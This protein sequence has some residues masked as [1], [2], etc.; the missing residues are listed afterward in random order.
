MFASK[1]KRLLWHIPHG[2]LAAYLL[3]KTPFIWA[4]IGWVA[5]IITYQFLEEIAI[6]DKSYLDFRGYMVGFA[7][8]ILLDI[9]VGLRMHV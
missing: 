3:T 1:W 4:G 2:V 7:A 9:V 6:G 8:M 5:M